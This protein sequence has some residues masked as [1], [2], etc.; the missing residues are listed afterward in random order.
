M[1]IKFIVYLTVN[2]VNRKIYVGVHKTNP[3]TFDGYIGCD[4]WHW[5]KTKL[6]AP[7]TAFHK[8]VRKYGYDKFERITLGIFDTAEEAYFEES[9]IVDTKF[10]QRKDTYNVILGGR[11]SATYTKKLLQYSLDGKFLKQWDSMISAAEYY[12]KKTSGPIG[13]VCAG[14]SKSYLGFQWRYY[15]ED[16]PTVIPPIDPGNAERLVQYTLAG[17]LVKVWKSAN[18]AGKFFNCKGEILKRKTQTLKPYAGSQ[19]RKYSDTPPTTID[20]WID[21]KEIVQLTDDYQIVKIWEN[22]HK[23]KLAGFNN[24]SKAVKFGRKIKGFHWMYNKDYD[25]LDYDIVLSD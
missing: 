23:I 15:T 7:K 24:I 19:W 6:E 3:K 1:K 9:V 13:S 5:S 18:S 4:V 8:A 12:N 14:K 2:T 20:K 17:E 16:Y 11:S 25:K 10:V 21:P 22:S